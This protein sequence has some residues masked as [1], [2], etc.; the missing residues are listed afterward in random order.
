MASAS[1]EELSIRQI[2]LSELEKLS[3]EARGFRER[4]IPIW[5]LYLSPVDS[6][7]ALQ[8]KPA[9]ICGLPQWPLDFHRNYV[10]A[11]HPVVIRH[12][13]DH[14]PALSKWNT[15]EDGFRYLKTQMSG[16]QVTVALTPN[17]RAD[18][19]EPAADGSPRLCFPANRQMSMDELLD[20]LSNGAGG[21]TAGAVHYCQQQDNNFRE[22]FPPLHED[23]D[24]DGIELFNEAF[25]ANPE[26]ANI[27]IGDSRSTTTAHKDH[28]DNI[29][30]QIAGRKTFHLVPP[31][32]SWRLRTQPVLQDQ[33]THHAPTSSF[34]R[35]PVDSPPVPWI[36]DPVES[37]P[38][39]KWGPIRVTLGPGDALYLPPL[40]V[41]AVTQEPG[42][43][44]ININYWYD[45]Q[46]TSTYAYQQTIS[47]LAERLQA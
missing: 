4:V 34:S 30:C 35:E 40:W 31:S 22:Q 7:E 36:A 19:L 42:Q 10:A 46:F 14:W 26:V 28:Y 44:C 47:R 38:A 23:V 27:W 39:Q 16:F 41:H 3:K 20:A 24:I 43:V 18:A 17:G 15:P 11:S 5:S 25:G 12:A 1:T 21:E 13:F 32:D 8:S 6:L 45:M 33:Y 29:V 2:L 9:P 37:M